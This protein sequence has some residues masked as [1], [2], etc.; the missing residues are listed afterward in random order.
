MMEKTTQLCA[1]LGCT[2][3]RIYRC[4]IN[5]THLKVLHYFDE[6]VVIPSLQISFFGGILP[7][8]LT[9]RTGVILNVGC[10]LFSYANTGAMEPIGT[11]IATNVEP[12]GEVECVS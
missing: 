1:T 2:Y 4:R 12:K 10:L 6:V 7:L 5:R 11:R 9:F 3:C 8:V